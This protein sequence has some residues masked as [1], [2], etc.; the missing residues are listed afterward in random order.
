MDFQTLTQP[1][2]IIVDQDH[3]TAQATSSISLTDC[4]H[5]H[6]DLNGYCTKC[7]QWDS[8]D[9]YEELGTKRKRQ[10]IKS[11]SKE[12]TALGHSGEVV[13]RADDI[14]QRISSGSTGKCIRRRIIF[15]CVFQAHI[16]MGICVDP[17]YM[18]RTKHNLTTKDINQAFTQYGSYANTGYD[19][20]LSFVDPVELI[21]YYCNILGVWDEVVNFIK[22]KYTELTENYPGIKQ[23]PVRPTLAA[24]I[25]I[26]L[27]NFGVEPNMES[28]ADI[29]T[30][31]PSTVKSTITY[32]MQIQ[33]PTTAQ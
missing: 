26:M 28:Y 10:V 12:L 3:V 30:L 32:F 1:R 15:W 17:F 21:P 25:Y 24:F 20:Q 5:E 16:Q 33:R 6:R 11:I 19:G 13:S 27:K 7:G 18:G 4:P 22:D 8:V 2:L 31:S 29:F 9:A 14:Y 23:K